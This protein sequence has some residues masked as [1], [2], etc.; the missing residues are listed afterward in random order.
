[1][2][3]FSNALL[4]EEVDG[5]INNSFPDHTTTVSCI[6]HTEKDDF[7]PV[8]IISYEKKD[9]YCADATSVG[10]ITLV[11][12]NLEFKKLLVANRDNFQISIYIDYNGKRVKER[13][14]GVLVTM[15][16][17]D[18]TGDVTRELTN[19][20]VDGDLIEVEIQC[21]SFLFS[22]LKQITINA[23]LNDTTV[24]EVIR[25]Y[26]GTEM[27]KVRINNIP[28]PM[29]I[30]MVKP[31]NIRKYHSIILKN[32]TGLLDIPTELQTQDYGIYNG[33]VGTYVFNKNGKDTIAVFPLYNTDAPADGIKL[34]IYVSDTGGVADLSNKTVLLDNDIL[35][36]IVQ[37]DI[38]RIDNGDLADYDSGGGFKATNSNQVL[39]RTF[40]KSG[41]VLKTD[42]SNMIDSQ[43]NGSSNSMATVKM[44]KPGDNLYAIRSNIIK[45]KGKILQ[46]QWS[47]SRPDY[48]YPGMG[49]TIIRVRYN[50][51]IREKGILLSHFSR[52]DN[53]HKTCSTLLNVMIN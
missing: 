3:I 12:G 32:T 19:N 41:G 36:I 20:A 31:H 1:M 51:I 30:D 10:I 33:D 11:M 40:T 43:S 48:L 24:E 13:C 15:P 46:M 39:D 2:K 4:N 25:Y 28:V 44:L 45:N 27:T 38:G 49:V 18:M 14:K 23:T 8:N 26:L 42:S 5:I 53:K 17:D 6:I 52:Y 9:D 21:V 7:Y 16:A 50:K 29:S 47:F 35:K 34:S 22:I 37:T